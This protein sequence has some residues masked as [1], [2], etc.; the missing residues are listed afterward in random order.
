MCIP[1][2]VYVTCPENSFHLSGEW[3]SPCISA[4][5][6]RSA[7][8]A[9][10]ILQCMYWCWGSSPLTWTLLTAQSIVLFPFIPPAPNPS[11]RNHSIYVLHYTR[12]SLNYT[13][14]EMREWHC[15]GYQRRRRSLWLRRQSRR[16]V[17]A[18]V[19]GLRVLIPPGVW[20]LCLVSVVCCQVEVCAD[21]TSREVL[22]CV[23][24]VCV[25]VWWRNNVVALAR[26]RLLCHKANN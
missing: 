12:H 8:R 26:V 6:G 10:F 22:P 19:M 24:C 13:Y 2:T 14:A 4:G 1:T 16:S 15:V 25:C 23:L 21:P 7:T 18:R 17:A 5:D 3:T 9:C 20:C 11:H